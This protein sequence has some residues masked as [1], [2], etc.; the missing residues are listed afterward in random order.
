ME[1]AVSIIKLITTSIGV[2]GS[3]LDLLS[4][5]SGALSSGSGLL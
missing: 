2:A 3:T 4:S 1:L 5:G